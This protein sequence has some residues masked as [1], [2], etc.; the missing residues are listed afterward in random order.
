MSRRA[1]TK[2]RSY[3]VRLA[4][5]DRVELTEHVGAVGR[6]GERGTVVSEPN[7]GFRGIEA[8][9]DMDGS[10]RLTLVSTGKLRRI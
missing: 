5:G 9:L 7:A 6:A 8:Y 1:D 3:G 2:R 4:R 10:G